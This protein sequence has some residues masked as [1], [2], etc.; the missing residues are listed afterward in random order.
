M[1]GVIKDR[2]TEFSKCMEDTEAL[3]TQSAKH[4]EEAKESLSVRMHFLIQTKN[5]QL[6]RY[7]CEIS[8]VST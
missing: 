1:V 4:I 2:K 3:L 8:H 5:M 6:W 7:N